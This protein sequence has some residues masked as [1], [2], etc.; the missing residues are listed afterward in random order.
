[1]RLLRPHWLV[2]LALYL[3]VI[4]H[5]LSGIVI[6]RR[7]LSDNNVRVADCFLPSSYAQ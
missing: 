2:P 4:S 5:D 1:M 7:G 6:L 3:K